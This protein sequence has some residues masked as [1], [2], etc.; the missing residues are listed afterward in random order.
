MLPFLKRFPSQGKTLCPERSIAPNLS[1]FN[2]IQLAVR[3]RTL[4]RLV[5]LKDAFFLGQ[6]QPETVPTMP[7]K[8]SILRV[9]Y[10]GSRYCGYLAICT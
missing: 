6:A 5:H 8:G 10:R 9:K 4:K 7:Q 1:L 3:R 2:S